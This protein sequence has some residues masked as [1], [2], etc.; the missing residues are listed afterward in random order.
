MLAEVARKLADMPSL[1]SL[2]ASERQLLQHRYQ[3]LQELL[4]SEPLSTQIS[5]IAQ[6]C[7]SLLSILE[8]EQPP[9]APQ[10]ASAP[11]PVAP[12]PV[13]PPATVR[14]HNNEEKRRNPQTH[15]R[16]EARFQTVPSLT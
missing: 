16:H 4:L 12:P 6:E 2:S 11:P 3:R 13:T 15:K 1:A 14:L 9:M 5:V 7:S 10:P 8:H